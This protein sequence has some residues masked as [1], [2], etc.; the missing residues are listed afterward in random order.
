MTV[1]Y[2]LLGTVAA[3]EAETAV[4]EILF[5]GLMHEVFILGSRFRR[6]TAQEGQKSRH[7]RTSC[8][9]F[10][11]SERR[12]FA[13]G[14]AHVADHERVVIHAVEDEVTIGEYGSDTDIGHVGF[15]R[16]AGKVCTA[17]CRQARPRVIGT[18][19]STAAIA[20]RCSPAAARSLR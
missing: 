5:Y 1:V 3:N 2:G 12:P 11:P 13:R 4:L 14:V 19:S 18:P 8:G 17:G 20:P 7:H 10:R 15:K 16:Q 6:P 9:L